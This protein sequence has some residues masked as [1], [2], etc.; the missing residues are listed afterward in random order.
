MF[1]ELGDYRL[2]SILCSLSKAQKHIAEQIKNYLINYDLLDQY[3]QSAYKRDA[4]IQIA[5]I[6]VFD[7]VRRAT[8]KWSLWQSFLILRRHSIMFVIL[9]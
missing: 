7:D 4:S 6:R 5:L 8:I 3:Y 1:Y 9:N 2:I